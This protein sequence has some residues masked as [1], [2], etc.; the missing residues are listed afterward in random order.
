MAESNTQTNPSLSFTDSC[1]ACYCDTMFKARYN[2]VELIY[3]CVNNINKIMP[4]SSLDLDFGKYN[5]N[6]PEVVIIM[7]KKKI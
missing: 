2:L 3:K 4:M 5:D 1:G 7:I 6:L